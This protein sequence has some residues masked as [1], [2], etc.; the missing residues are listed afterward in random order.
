MKVKNGYKVKA[1]FSDNEIN[2]L[3]MLAMH[4]NDRSYAARKDYPDVTK[5]A[6]DIL[7]NVVVI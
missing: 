1:V 4:W 2:A 6:D 7:S 3:R 5:L